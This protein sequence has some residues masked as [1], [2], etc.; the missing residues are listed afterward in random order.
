MSGF[1][2][3]CTSSWLRRRVLS[4][5]RTRS[6]PSATCCESTAPVNNAAPGTSAPSPARPIWATTV[7]DGDG[8]AAPGS[9]GPGC[10]AE[11]A[12]SAWCLRCR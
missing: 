3:S 7:L 6:A 4:I 10:G 1:I 2:T 12:L 8:T 5:A 9:P 11:A